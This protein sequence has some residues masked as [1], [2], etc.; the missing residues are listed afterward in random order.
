MEGRVSVA[1]TAART[2]SIQLERLACAEADIEASIAHFRS[3]IAALYDHVD[4]G[5]E[6]SL[7]QRHLFRRDQVRATGRCIEAI[8]RLFL[9]SGSSAMGEQPP[10]VARVA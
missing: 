3:S 8:D 1:G 5:G 9:S 4:A 7:D 2:S 6:I 10:G